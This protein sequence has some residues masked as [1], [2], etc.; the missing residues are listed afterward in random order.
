MQVSQ[1]AILEE[2][3]QDRG[4]ACI[5]DVVAMQDKLFDQG[6]FCLLLKEI[7]LEGRAVALVER[8]ALQV[9]YVAADLREN[10]EGHDFFFVAVLHVLDIW[11]VR[12]VVR[13]RVFRKLIKDGF[14]DVLGRTVRLIL[15]TLVL[16]VERDDQLLE[17]L[18][19]VRRLHELLQHELGALGERLAPGLED[20]SLLLGYRDR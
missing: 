7:L 18:D 4:K 6:F 17:R 14:V 8:V 5:R 3:G 19:E 13:D 10:R 16:V 11:V 12:C 9:E 1:F 2:A 15:A 20:L